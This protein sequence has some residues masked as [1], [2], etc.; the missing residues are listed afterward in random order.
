[1]AL[2]AQGAG[3]MG[4]VGKCFEANAVPSPEFCIPTS[5]D[6]VWH[7]FFSCPKNRTAKYPKRSLQDAEDRLQ[8]AGSIHAQRLY[9]FL[10]QVCIQ[11]SEE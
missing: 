6:T 3:A 8:Q 10:P 4:I 7:S 9:F 5:I 1:M 11:Q 2:I